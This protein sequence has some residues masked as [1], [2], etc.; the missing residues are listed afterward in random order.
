MYH[1]FPFNT[2]MPEQKMFHW[3]KKNMTNIDLDTSIFVEIFKSEV[4]Y[5]AKQIQGNFV[6]KYHK[7]LWKDCT[8][9]LF[10]MKSSSLWHFPV[11]PQET[12]TWLPV[13]PLINRNNRSTQILAGIMWY[14]TGLQC[15]MVSGYRQWQECALSQL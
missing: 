6:K 13:F 1:F 9:L 3:T 15:Y 4:R 5:S 8:V 7:V 14:S 2:Y 11:S 10:P 12:A